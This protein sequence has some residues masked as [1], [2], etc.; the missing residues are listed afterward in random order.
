MCGRFTLRTPAKVL[1]DTFDADEPT[2][3]GP[4]YNIAPTQEILHLRQDGLGKRTWHQARWGLVPSW[5]EEVGGGPPLI[6]AR[7]ETAATKPAFRSAFRQ[8]RCLIPA[9]G[10]YEWRSSDGA[11]QPFYISRAEGQPIAFAGLWERWS[12]DGKVIESCAI[13]TTTANDLMRRLHDRMPVILFHDSFEIWLSDVSDPTTM[14]TP[15]MR[16]CPSEELTMAPVSRRVNSVRFDDPEC[17]APAP[18]GPRQQ[19]LF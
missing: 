17:L 19:T 15:L 1:A 18:E 2:L 5:S 16:P 12:R 9:D 11:S 13:L 7:S 3:F 10:F 4:R 6:N 14:L 8:R